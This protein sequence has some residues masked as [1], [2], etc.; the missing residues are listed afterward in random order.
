MVSSNWYSKW[1]IL[2]AVFSQALWGCAFRCGVLPTVGSRTHA[3]CRDMPCRAYSTA[4]GGGGDLRGRNPWRS[5]PSG[6]GV[7]LL[8]MDKILHHLATLPWKGRIATPAPR[9]QCWRNPFE[10]VVQDFG[11]ST[12]FCFLT[13]VAPILTRENEGSKKSVRKVVQDCVHQQYDPMTVK[14]A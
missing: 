6:P 2:V 14:Y 13:V 3:G 9:I 7:S 10:E 4:S 5:K 11:H 1:C 8:L 12:C